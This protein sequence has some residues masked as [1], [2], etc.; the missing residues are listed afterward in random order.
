MNP[1]QVLLVQTSFDNIVPIRATVGALFYRSLFERDPDLRA[2]FKGD[3]A[4]QSRK[5]MAMIEMVVD[6]LSQF[7]TLLPPL[8]ALG[9]A[10]VGYGVQDA[11]Y[12]VVGAA[13]L[14]ALRVSLEEGFSAADEAAWAEAYALL[15]STMKAA[16][17]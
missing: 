11:H 13:L 4:A 12:E 15:A 2:L 1:Q 17:A 6:N 14:A 10:H 9:R 8:R 16:A 5:L 7:D 3:M